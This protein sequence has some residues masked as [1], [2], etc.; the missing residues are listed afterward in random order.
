MSSTAKEHLVESVTC[1]AV[2]AVVFGLIVACGGS[3]SPLN[4]I[5]HGSSST[6][7]ILSHLSPTTAA[8]PQSS[9]AP[10]IAMAFQS[11]TQPAAQIQQSFQGLSCG[12][13]EP[14]STVNWSAATTGFIPIEV[15]GD[16][17]ILGGVGGP[18]QTAC[19]G[20]FAQLGGGTN[21]VPQRGGTLTNPGVQIYTDGTLSTLIVTGISANGQQIRC[22][23]LTDTAPVQDAALVQPYF[24]IDSNSVVLA[25]GSTQLP[26]TCQLNIAS[27]DQA[28][29]ISVQWAKI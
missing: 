8:L 24:V 29:S 27:G 1:T 9:Q 23:D 6:G 25:V 11:S 12:A 2:F 4:R 19:G 10:L 28:G 21:L 15:L 26:L 14:G 18:Q 16:P 7:R 5:T 17:F 20:V 3:G 22:S 13:F